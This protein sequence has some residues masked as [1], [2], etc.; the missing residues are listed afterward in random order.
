LSGQD[1]EVWFRHAWSVREEEVYP[2]L[3]GKGTGQIYPLDHDIFSAFSKGDVD[4]RWL[5]QGVLKFPPTDARS[6]WLFVTSGLSNA[7]FED[8]PNPDGWSGF[9]CELVLEADGDFGWALYLL[10]RLLAFQILLGWGRYEGKALVAIGDR[11][12]LR[13]PIDSGESPLTW[14]LMAPPLGY[15][16]RF[17]LPSGNVDFL[18]VVGIT[19]AEAE[20]AR[21][22]GSGELLSRLAVRGYQITR[23]A[24]AGVV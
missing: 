21:S 16:D 8:Q 14:C 24:R 3:F 23:P 5:F 15:T 18:H 17:H 9:G 4:P 11:I 2:K 1:W 7:W 19:E 12:P 6:S 20:F 13:Q 22:E 10:R